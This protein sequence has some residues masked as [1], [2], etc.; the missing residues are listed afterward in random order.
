MRIRLPFAGVF[1]LLLLTAGYAGLSSLQVNA[2]INDKLLHFLTFFLLTVVF[3]WVVDTNRRRTLNLTLFLCTFCLGV[4]SEFLQALL[5]NGREFDLYDVIAN[6]VGSL[7]GVALC[8][9]YHKRMLERKRTRKY[10]AVPGEEG[11]D[12]VLHDGDDLEEDLELG[13]G[14]GL[15]SRQEEGVTATVPAVA[16]PAAAATVTSLED[17]VD[18]W[19]ENAVDNWDDEDDIGDIGTSKPTMETTTTTNGDHGKR[20]AD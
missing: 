14:I 20:R 4:G 2:V 11:D 3:Y 7:T 13:E 19:D 15:S 9:W 17:E 16:T 6:L 18:N 12:D 10:T 5:P 1:T 8:S